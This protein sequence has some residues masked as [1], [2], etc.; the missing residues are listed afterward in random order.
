MTE[1]ELKKRLI[2]KIN[3]TNNNEILEEAYRLLCNEEAD[4]SVYEFSPEQRNAIDE[5]Q[6]QYRNG[7]FLTNEQADK[8]IDEWLDK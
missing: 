7:Q 4:N 2:V 6:K 5:A 1:M 3:Q 8:A